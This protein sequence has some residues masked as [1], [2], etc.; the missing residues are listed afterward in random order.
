METWLRLPPLD[1][2]CFKD[3]AKIIDSEINFDYDFKEGMIEY[4]L[5]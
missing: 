5:L 4:G 3:K 1:F 2:A